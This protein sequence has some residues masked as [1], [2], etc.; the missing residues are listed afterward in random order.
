MAA[1]PQPFNP[2]I[3]NTMEMVEQQQIGEDITIP[4]THLLNTVGALG[5][6]INDNND[7]VRQFKKLLNDFNGPIIAF[8]ALI[9]N[10]IALLKRVPKSD[11]IKKLL[12]QV[13][14]LNK[15]IGEV[16]DRLQEYVGTL[17][18]NITPEE[19]R[20]L[21]GLEGQ[22]ANIIDS[23]NQLTQEYNRAEAENP[24]PPAGGGGRKSKRRHHKKKKT[25]KHKK[26]QKG[27]YNYK[28]KYTKMAKPKSKSSSSSWRYSK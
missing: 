11:A 13:D 16:D 10:I 24:R 6:A 12:N 2:A 15:V 9:P 19:V 27:G 7:K 21:G 5:T 18:N 23:I 25:Q 28:K 8:Y 1:P 26:K 3:I 4:P 17:S 20:T 22:I 14:V